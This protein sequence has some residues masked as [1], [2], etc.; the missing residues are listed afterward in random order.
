MQAEL[1]A[2]KSSTPF[3]EPSDTNIRTIDLLNELSRAIPNQIE[4]KFTKLVFSAGSVLISGNT[5][6][7]NAVDD[8]KNSLEKSEIFKTVT[9]SSANM[10]RSGKR[11]DFKLKIDLS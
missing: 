2:Q 7:F 4:A 10:D 8:M 6:T 5:D 3:I 1:K 9:I 11:V